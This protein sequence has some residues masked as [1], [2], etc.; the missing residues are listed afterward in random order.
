MHC[1]AL[2]S[3]LTL[4][5]LGSRSARCWTVDKAYL[6]PDWKLP[7]R[8]LM[9]LLRPPE[10]SFDNS[11]AA[12]QEMEITHPVTEVDYLQMLDGFGEG[13]VVLQTDRE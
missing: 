5:N 11:Q 3:E 2:V 6:S 9:P 8:R 1:T 12:Q 10:P 7:R 13:G 4:E